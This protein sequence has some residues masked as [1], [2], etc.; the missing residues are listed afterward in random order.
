MSLDVDRGVRARLERVGARLVVVVACVACLATQ[1]AAWRME[2]KVPSAPAP[3]SGKAL[4]VTVEASHA[5][6]LQVTSGGTLAPWLDKPTSPTW[7]GTADYFVDGAVAP[8]YASI[9]DRCTSGGG[10][11]SGCEPPPGA[12]VR[13]T[14]VS[15]V[16]IWVAQA[17][18]AIAAGKNARIDV[19]IE[20]TREPRVESSV[21]SSG[22]CSTGFLSSSPLAATS[23][24]AP[25]SSSSGAVPSSS[26][27]A[28]SS[29]PG[30]APSS[31]PSGEPET[32]GLVA[33]QPSGSRGARRMVFSCWV[34]AATTITASIRGVCAGGP[35]ATPPGE[36]VAILRTARLP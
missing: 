33:P 3:A 10:L 28:A 4:R 8:D 26:A 36:S 1:P 23:G 17:T 21:P 29:V 27:S 13:I 11:C 18:A 35:C 12:F 2:A 16:D 19:E 25:S 6:S 14:S 7:P 20:A 5:P 32:P 22:S 9:G 31:A 30:A 34:D 15:E 24:A